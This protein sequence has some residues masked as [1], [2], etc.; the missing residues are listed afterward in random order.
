MAQ[1]TIPELNATT[2]IDENTILPVDSGVQ[3]FKA[4]AKTLAKAFANLSTTWNAVQTYVLNDLVYYGGDI[5]R[6]LA[7]S[8]TGNN[9]GADVTKWELIRQNGLNP[10]ATL[11]HAYRAA[12]S[13]SASP[14]PISSGLA[15]SGLCYSKEQDKLVA[16]AI[17][18]AVT[19]AVSYSEDGGL[20]WT[21]ADAPASASPTEW[22]RIAYSPELNLY[23]MVGGAA[24]SSEFQ[25][26]TSPDAITWTGRTNPTAKS[27]YNVIWIPEL[28]RFV[29]TGGDTEEDA[30]CYSTNGTAWTAGDAPEGTW[31]NLAWSA[32]LSKLVSLSWTAS[33]AEG[34]RCMFSEDGGATWELV[35]IPDQNY[36]FTDMV[37]SKDRRLFVA[38]GTGGNDA[39]KCAMTSVDG[40]TWVLRTMPSNNDWS[41]LAESPELGLFVAVARDGSNRAAFSRDGVTWVA[42]TGAVS[43]TWEALEWL[44]KWGRFAAVATTYSVTAVMLSKF[45]GAFV[46]PRDVA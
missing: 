26:A 6:S 36:L 23:V 42:A 12:N 9:P 13:W 25:I 8:N 16:C 46:A 44:P 35:L 22:S 41:G 11:A 24:G 3:T 33:G 31:G 20:T 15:F 14:A 27:L 1:K 7:G 39:T 4:T 17:D 43:E 29:A 21:D 34:D 19:D 32:H 28:G 30:V 45:V 37:Y 5:Y 38:I 2:T 10:Q 18:G 40:E